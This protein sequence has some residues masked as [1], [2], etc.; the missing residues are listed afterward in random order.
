MR[1]LP[2]YYSLINHQCHRCHLPHRNCHASRYRR[3]FRG[4][5]RSNRHLLPRAGVSVAERDRAHRFIRKRLYRYYTVNLCG[6]QGYNIHRRPPPCVIR[7]IRAWFPDSAGNYCGYTLWSARA[8]QHSAA[9][10]DAFI[11]GP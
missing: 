5:I 11:D 10:I 6:V 7:L 4:Y 1:Y 3:E 2:P 9:R 8:R